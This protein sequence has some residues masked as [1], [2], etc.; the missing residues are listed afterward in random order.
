MTRLINVAGG[1]CAC[2][3]LMSALGGCGATAPAQAVTQPGAFT[4]DVLPS[5][6]DT[7]QKKA[8]VDFVRR[9][10][11]SAAP[12]SCRRQTG[13]PFLT[14]IARYGWKPAYCSSCLRSR[15]FRP[16]R[17]SIPEW[18]SQ[19]PYRSALAG[20]M[21]GV[22]A[23]NGEANAM[24]LIVATHAGMSADQFATQARDWLA[25][26]RHKRF[27]RTY[28]QLVYQPMLEVLTY[29]RANGFKAFIVSG[30]GVEFYARIRRSS[31][32]HPAGAGRRQ[33]H[34]VS[35]H[36]SRWPT[37]AHA[38]RKGRKR[39]RRPRLNQFRQ[40]KGWTAGAD[41]SVAVVKVR[42]TARSTRR[43]R[44]RRFKSSP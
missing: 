6:N 4:N 20:D 35:V 27:D 2:L 15:G 3:V 26:A 1:L 44:R 17:P 34:P 24:R 30:G 40:S 25:S 14:T 22:F 42:A 19:E 8:I 36:R 39:R 11:P 33:Q 18:R 5:W 7:A 41:A 43:P 28:P 29:I 21:A 13:L 37:D 32:W 38:H 9:R 16:R 23:E 10:R 12:T 31:V